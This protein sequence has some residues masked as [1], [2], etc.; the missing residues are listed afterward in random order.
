MGDMH[1]PCGTPV[2]IRWR[3]SLLPSRHRVAFQSWRKECTHL[4]IGSG[5]WWDRRVLS[6]CEC[7][8][9]SKKPVMSNV[10]MDAFHLWFHAVSMSCTVH[11]RSSLADLPGMPPNCDAGNRLCFAEM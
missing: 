11:N 8:I 5:M 9:M 2:L 10:R 7:G 6:R 3:S 1:K 4:V